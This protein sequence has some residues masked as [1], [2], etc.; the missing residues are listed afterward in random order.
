[1]EGF[2]AKVDRGG[3]TPQQAVCGR[4]FRKDREV[5]IKIAA[6]KDEGS[7]TIMGNDVIR[8]EQRVDKQ[9]T[10]RCSSFQSLNLHNISLKAP[11]PSSEPIT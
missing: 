1:M 5:N 11:G 8:V 9:N 10:P 3:R 7:C 6:A 2:E 4:S